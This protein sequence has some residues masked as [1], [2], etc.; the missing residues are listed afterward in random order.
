MGCESCSNNASGLPRGCKNNGACGISGCDKLEVF[1]W[2]AGMQL[3]DHAKLFDIIEVRFKSSRKAFFRNADGL[4]LH[5]GDV[6]AIDASPGYD[7]GVVSLTGELVRVQMNRRNVKDTIEIKKV[8]R[9]ATNEDIEKWQEARKKETDTMIRARKIADSCN[10]QMKISDVEYQGDGNKATFYYTAEDRVD[11]R[12]LIRALAEAFRVRIE[13]RQIGMRQ[14]AGRLGGIGSCGRELCCSTW[15][16]D[17]R[18]VS[19][20]AARYQQLSLNPQKLAGQCGKLKCCLNFELDQYREA[21][22][23]FPPMNTKLET[24]GGRASL[25]KIDIFK[26]LLYFTLDGQFGASP[27]ALGLDEVLDIIEMNKRGEKPADINEFVVTEAVEEEVTFLNDMGQDSITR[28]DRTK[29]RRNNN[30][31]K[32]GGDGRQPQSGGNR[33]EGRGQ[34]SGGERRESNRPKG[35]RPQGQRPQGPRPQG[36]RPEGATDAPQR[37]QGGGGEA[38]RRNRPSRRKRGGNGPKPQGQGGGDAS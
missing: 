9:K 6:V 16:S 33:P 15:L 30:R 31:R 34:Q 12:E 21:V 28:F 13:M 23:E 24:A 3:P 2:L 26:R 29:P 36:P 35:P 5:I 10:L 11:F 1:D 37:E 27:V 8:L 22:K 7:V 14:E 20:S 25:F 38:N 17:F 18:S 19:T 4:E 32:R